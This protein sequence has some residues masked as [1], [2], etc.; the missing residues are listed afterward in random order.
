MP[1]ASLPPLPVAAW[2]P[3]G[4]FLPLPGEL[5]VYRVAWADFLPL[6]A[7]LLALVPAD[8]RARAARYVQPAD[9]ARF[10][11]GRAALRYL[12]GQQLGLLP[13]AVPLT[14]TSFGKPRL[15]APSGIHFNFSHSGAWVVLVLAPFEVGIDVEE[16]RPDFDYSEIASYHFGPAS[17]QYLQQSADPRGAFYY[18]WTRREALAKAIGRGLDESTDE[19]TAPPPDWQLPSFE[20]A[21]GYPAALAFP[22]GWQPV[23]RFVTLAAPLFG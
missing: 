23:L 9:Q 2:Q 15:A 6:P 8:E 13:A 3:R 18:L 4:S 16:V 14:L 20:V 10:L 11:V 12:L 1:A 17:R 22:A 5:A 7:S 21:T 19:G